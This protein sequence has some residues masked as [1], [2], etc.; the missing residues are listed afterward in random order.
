MEENAAPAAGDAG[1][2]EDE[3]LF[4]VTHDILQM[5]A[6][7][8]LFHAIFMKVASYY[9]EVVPKWMRTSVEIIVL[10]KVKI[11]PCFGGIKTV[12]ALNHLCNFL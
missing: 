9:V 2:N 12:K 5:N 7:N 11:R 8:R 6:R 10:M 3:L 4:D 1:H